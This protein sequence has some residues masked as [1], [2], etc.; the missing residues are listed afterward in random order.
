MRRG[1][2]RR[3]YPIAPNCAWAALLNSVHLAG[4]RDGRRQTRLAL[5]RLSKLTD[6]DA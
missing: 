2:K 4:T 5:N 1:S 3:R 6:F